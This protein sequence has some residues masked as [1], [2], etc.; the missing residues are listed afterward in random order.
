MGYKRALDLAWDDLIGASD[1]RIYSL[2][3][4]L[5]TYEV[6]TEKRAIHSSSDGEPAKDFISILIL[7]YLVKKLRLGRL[8]SPSGDWIDFNRLE[9]GEGYYGA[10]KKRTIDRLIKKFGASPETMVRSAERFPSIKSSTGDE[11]IILY[12]IDDIP[13]M[14]TAWKGDEEFGPDIN[15]VFD[16]SISAIFCTEDIVVLTEAIVHQL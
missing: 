6:D 3:F 4:L 5:D 15:I 7:H 9:G 2:R 13:V 12:P 11:G 10:F 14:V 16:K 1:R 8:P